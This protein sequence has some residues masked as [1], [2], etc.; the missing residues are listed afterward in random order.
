[1]EQRFEILT[2]Q[3]LI[4]NRLRMSFAQDRTFELWQNFMPRR[5]EIGNAINPKEFIS[6]RVYDPTYDF[7][8]FNPSAEFDKWAG[9]LVSD[10]DSIP[11]GMQTLAIPEGLYAVFSYKGSPKKAAIPFGYIFGNWLPDS[12][13]ELDTRPHFEILGEKYKNDSEDSEE[14][15]WVPIKRKQ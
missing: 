10:F 14:E 15:I 12:E 4:G 5:N 8:K 6:M 9:I 13:Y 3:K 7:K 1:M 11:E 2:S